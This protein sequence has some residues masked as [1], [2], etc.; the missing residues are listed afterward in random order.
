MANKN[1]TKKVRRHSGRYTPNIHSKCMKFDKIK[2]K[3][4]EPQE[5]Y[6]DWIDYRDGQRDIPGLER[7][8]VEIKK[9]KK[10]HGRRKT[11]A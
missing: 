11:R 1:I 8:K 6:D 3:A 10:K 2:D 5:E 4:L 9:E 7:K